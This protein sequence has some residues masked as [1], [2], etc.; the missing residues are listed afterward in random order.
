MI[1]LRE[2][3]NSSLFIPKNSF[4]EKQDLKKTKLYIFNTKREIPLSFSELFKA[5]II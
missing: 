2:K 4:R 3:I 1:L 5:Q